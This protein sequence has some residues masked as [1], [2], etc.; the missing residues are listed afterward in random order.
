MRINI[1]IAIVLVIILIVS[2]N[3]VRKKKLDVKYSMRWIAC[4]IFF[5]LID[6]FT[7]TVE[8]AA[9]FVGVDVPINLLFFIGICICLM[10]IFNMTVQISQ[11]AD[12]EK[13]LIQE[14]ALLRKELDEMKEAEKVKEETA[15]E[16]NE[17]EKKQQKR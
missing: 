13:R 5:L 1:I 8:K 16:I 2:I 6:I 3:Q 15:E 11:H 10:L 12:R 7:N 4:L 14:L 9:D 17:A